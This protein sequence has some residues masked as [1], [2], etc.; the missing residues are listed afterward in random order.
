MQHQEIVSHFNSLVGALKEH[1]QYIEIN[2][3][4]FRKLLKHHDKQV[5]RQYHARSAPFLDF[6][7]LVTDSSCE[8]MQFV[9]KFGA[10]LLDT[11]VIIAHQLGEQPCIEDQC[12]WGPESEEVLKIRKQ[13]HQMKIPRELPCCFAR[14]GGA[15]Y[16]KPNSVHLPDPA[17]RY[18]DVSH[19]TGK[20]SPD[21]DVWS[22]PGSVFAQRSINLTTLHYDHGEHEENVWQASGDRAGLLPIQPRFA[23]FANLIRSN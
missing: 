1:T 20:A 9:R 11:Q 16:S 15:F 2:V 8:F 18:T 13:L 10:A 19:V 5:P 17:S 12:G 21:S 3:A 22:G 7:S 6:H 14:G 23:P 4:G